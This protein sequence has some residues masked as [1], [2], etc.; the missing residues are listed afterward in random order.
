MNFSAKLLFRVNPV[1]RIHLIFI[2]LHL[3]Y[4]FLKPEVKYNQEK[5]Q[6]AILK[7]LYLYLTNI[8]GFCFQEVDG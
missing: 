2:E 6:I 4:F 1:V 7:H 8:V 3:D 5:L